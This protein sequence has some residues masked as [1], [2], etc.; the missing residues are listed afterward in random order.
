MLSKEKMIENEKA[1]MK[2]NNVQ[3]KE[4][5]CREIEIIMGEAY[6]DF[7]SRSLALGGDFHKRISNE[8]NTQKAT[9]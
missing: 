3:I 9:T 7:V 5:D 6:L 8:E 1:G 2:E 4:G